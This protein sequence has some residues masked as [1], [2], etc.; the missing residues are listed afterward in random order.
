[1]AIL[2]GTALLSKFGVGDVGNV[3]W[4]EVIVSRHT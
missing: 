1:M 2:G 4:A 3:P